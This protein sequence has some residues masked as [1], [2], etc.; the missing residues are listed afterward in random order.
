MHAEEGYLY[1]RHENFLEESLEAGRVKA[2]VSAGHRTACRNRSEQT[3]RSRADRSRKSQ[4]SQLESTWS[5]HALCQQRASHAAVRCVSSGP[6]VSG[7]QKRTRKQRQCLSGARGFRFQFRGTR[8][9]IREVSPGHRAG[10]AK[11]GSVADL[12]HKR[13]PGT[14]ARHVRARHRIAHA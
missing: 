6:C 8:S 11:G 10:D 5:H 7:A 3:R 4:R 13:T 14:I 2:E 1:P 12:P 9:S